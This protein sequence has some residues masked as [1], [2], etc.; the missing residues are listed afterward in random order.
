MLRKRQFN[1]SDYPTIVGWWQGWGWKKVPPLSSLPTRTGLVIE[2]DNKPVIA[3]FI[4]ITEVSFSFI[5]WLVSDKTI[6]DKEVRKQC[7]NALTSGLIEMAKENGK[8][9][10]F[11]CTSNPFLVRNFKQHG[12][13]TLE[14][15]NVTMGL[16]FS[17]EDLGFMV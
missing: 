2:Y 14:P 12:L 4:Y 5:N 9:I 7:L 11:T 6:T 3:G 8:D 17:N 16:S 15:N 10:V 13:E 1:E